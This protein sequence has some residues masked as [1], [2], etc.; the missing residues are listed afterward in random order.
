MECHQAYNKNWNKVIEETEGLQS[1]PKAFWRNIRRIMGGN[2][3][4]VPFLKGNNGEKIYDEAGKVEI[5]KNIWTDIFRITVEEDREFDRTNEERVINYLEN[6]RNRITPNQRSD[7]NNLIINDPLL[8]PIEVRDL[9]I[10]IKKHE[11]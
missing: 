11:R 8:R 1:D 2:E 3:E 10:I 5:F 9:K 7:L 6:N 4:L